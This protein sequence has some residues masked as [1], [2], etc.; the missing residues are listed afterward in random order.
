L[1]V[2]KRK[3]YILKKGA[4]ISDILQDCPKIAEYLVEY[5]LLC[6]A[7]PFNQSET[8]EDGAKVHNMSD[9]DIQKMIKEI[10]EKLKDQ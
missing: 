3:P 9:K 8:L 10:N 2:T 1:I 6:V 5:G 7:C 4:V